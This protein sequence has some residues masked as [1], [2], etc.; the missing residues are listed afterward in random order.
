[1]S[2]PSV[3][4]EYPMMFEF[5]DEDLTWDPPEVSRSPE[6]ELIG[7]LFKDKTIRD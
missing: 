2:I 3:L 4:P 1:M 7:A 5:D 6:E